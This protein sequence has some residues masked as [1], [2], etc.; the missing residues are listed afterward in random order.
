MLSLDT[1][2]LVLHGLSAG[3]LAGASIHNALLSWRDYVRGRSTNVRLQRL[4]PRVIAGAW[5]FTFALGL[6]IYPAFRVGARVTTFD[7][8]LP[9]ATGFFEMKEHWLGIAALLLLYLV[10]TSAH[11]G[12][13]ATPPVDR[14]LYHLATIALGI[15]VAY[16][17][18]TGMTLTAIQPL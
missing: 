16:A 2:L 10:P 15:I 14:A 8:H 7:P 3:V 17:T 6:L 1:L 18:L 5:L 12:P 9:L 4:Y 13:R 11:L